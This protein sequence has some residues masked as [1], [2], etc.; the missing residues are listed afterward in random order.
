MENYTKAKNPEASRIADQKA[1]SAP[2]VVNES[3]RDSMSQLSMN[4][5]DETTGKVFLLHGT[6]PQHICSILFEGLDPCVANNGNFVRGVYF[7]DNSA[8]SDQY[9]S[10]DQWYDKDGRLGLL[11]EQIYGS[12]PHPRN[13]CY[14]LVSRVV[15]GNFVS[16]KNGFTHQSDGDTLFVDAHKSKLNSI[17]GTDSVSCCGTWQEGINF[18][19]SGC[20][21]PRSNFVEYLVAY[22]HCCTHCCGKPMNELTVVKEGTN[23]GR[24]ILRCAKECSFFQILPLC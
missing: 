9:A 13:V 8:K 20:F 3:Y 12:N 24:K 14:C 16:T 23:R 22:Q 2:L 4:C 10:L 15:S 7:A 18:P 11:H 17:E 6:S 21:F 19:G 1:P 5:L